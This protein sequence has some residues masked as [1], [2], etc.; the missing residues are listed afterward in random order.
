MPQREIELAMQLFPA[1][2]VLVNYEG[3]FTYPDRMILSHLCQ[4]LDVSKTAMIIRLR[5]L[6]YMEDRPYSEY[7]D[8]TEVWA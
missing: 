1:K 8:P 6:G 3:W 4:W 7:D 2:K 5:Q